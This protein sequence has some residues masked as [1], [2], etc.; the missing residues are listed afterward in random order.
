MKRLSILFWVALTAAAQAPTAEQIRET[1]AKVSEITGWAVK[2]PVPFAVVSRDEWKAWVE[3][4]IKEQAKP[5]EVRNEE[6]VIKMLGLAPRDFNLLSATVDLLGEQAAAVYDH[7]RKR[8]M[9]VEGAAPEDLQDAVL[10]HELSHA[11]ADQ[12]F[13]M[14]RFIEKGPKSD[15]Q[16]F[17]RMAVVEGQAMWIMVETMLS[18]MGQTLKD[19]GGALKAMLPMMGQM[20]ASQYPVFNKSPLYLRESLLFPYSGGMVFQQAVFE[21]IGKA[22][23]TEVLKKPPV[24]T[25]Q[26]LHPDKYFAGAAPA[27]AALPQTQLGGMA[28]RT[29]GDLGEFDLVIL[30]KEAG[31]NHEKAAAIAA[32]WRGGAYDL[33]DDKGSKQPLLR[34]TVAMKSEEDCI[35]LLEGL[36]PLVMKKSGG[37]KITQESAQALK[38]R[39]EDGEFVIE[40]KGSALNGVEGRKP[41]S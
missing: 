13:D 23:F 34:W 16:Q 40:V 33:H 37:A 6:T 26:I 19:N 41:G 25:Q 22:A 17:A 4:Q 31:L 36:K 21:K 27:K 14:G 28:K 10:V 15:E 7:R 11:L 2:K 1:V 29:S 35:R 32:G 8:M 3:E 9:F 38:G 12:H 18:R 5:E 24:S 30:L 20:A 39:N